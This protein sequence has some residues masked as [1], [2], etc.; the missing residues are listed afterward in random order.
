MDTSGSMDFQGKLDQVR[1]SIFLVFGLLGEDDYLSIVSFDNEID[2]IMDAKRWGDV[3][4]EMAER[5]LEELE[6]RG[7]TDLYSGVEEARDTLKGLGG[8]D[9][10]VT[11]RIL[12]L[13]DGRDTERDVSEFNELARSVAEEGIS[14]YSAGI[15]TYY[16]KEVIRLLGED[17]QGQWTHVNRPTDIRSFFG[18]VVQAASSVVANSPQLVIDPA[19]GTEIAEVYRRS[20]QVQEVTPEY[21][22]GDIIIGLP[23]LQEDQ[24]QTVVLKMDAPGRDVGSEHAL[25]TVGLEAGSRSAS[26]EVSVEYTDDPDKLAQQDE[27]VFLAHRDTAIRSSIAQADSEDDLEDV[28]SLI[29]ETEVITGETQI[30]DTLRDDVTRIES[31]DEE[32]VREVQEQ[33][34][35]VYEGNQFE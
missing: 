31:G 35:V 18:D 19:P 1:D 27:N 9:E 17:T 25:A 2:V 13:S 4:R 3:D 5:L 20:P 24:Q 34:T 22:D 15:G 11:K 30:I 8:E 28:E 32:Q 6:A 26:T 23:D 16:D 7:G 14:I 33:T 10:E 21:E 12:L 29:D